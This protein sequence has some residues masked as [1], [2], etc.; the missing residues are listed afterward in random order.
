MMGLSTRRVL[1]SRWTLLGGGSV[2]RLYRNGP[3]PRQGDPKPASDLQ[4]KA[5]N[6]YNAFFIG[7]CILCAFAFRYDKMRPSDIRNKIASI[8][9]ISL[10][11]P[12]TRSKKDPAQLVR[13]V[14][15]QENALFLTYA[16]IFP[17]S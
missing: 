10:E 5:S 17:P 4:K 3:Y 14:K 8:Y 12:N 2:G 7:A 11:T 16:E 9:S 15:N 6:I 13:G 1:F